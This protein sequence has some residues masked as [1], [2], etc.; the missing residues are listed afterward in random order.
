MIG[1]LAFCPTQ[2]G[3]T[4]QS[5]NRPFSV[6]TESHFRLPLLWCFGRYDR[7]YLYEA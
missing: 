4:M 6:P 5:S 2:D 7:F 1:A 3:R